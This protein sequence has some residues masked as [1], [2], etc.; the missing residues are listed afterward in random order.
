VFLDSRD[1]IGAHFA[2]EFPTVY[3]ACMSAGIDPSTHPIPVAPA[4]HYHMG[5]IATDPCGRTSLPGLWA[6]GECASTGLHGANRLASN[7]LLEALVF[8]ARAAED[9]RNQ[10]APMAP[11]IAALELR[12]VA[13]SPLPERL[14]QAMSA[15]LGLERTEE[16]MRSVLNTVCRLER[17]ANGD[18][19]LLNVAAAAKVIAVAGLERHESRGAHYRC[20]YPQTD[21]RFERRMLTLEQA[22]RIAGGA[23]SKDRLRARS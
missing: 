5:G 6:V 22:D 1:A 3:A 14:R 13:G 21:Q 10:F 4:A 18:P 9:V 15:H 12:P 7:S 19:A 11:R 16:G 8:G 23:V 2:E 17:A 20:D